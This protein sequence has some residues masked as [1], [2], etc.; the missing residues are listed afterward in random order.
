MCSENND[1]RFKCD[2][3]STEIAEK[4][5]KIGNLEIQLYEMKR[6]F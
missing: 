2:E 3:Y 1:L 6:K 4:D 5:E